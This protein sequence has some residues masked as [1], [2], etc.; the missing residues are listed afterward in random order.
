[1]SPSSPQSL[2]QL[3]P[4]AQQL[5]LLGCSNNFGEIPHVRQAD[6]GIAVTAVSPLMVSLVAATVAIVVLIGALV[7]P[8]VTVVPAVVIIV[9]MKTPV[10]L[11]VDAIVSESAGK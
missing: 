3:P 2:Y 11:V 9:L 7:I 10:V 6:E 8:T 5:G 1:M 4:R